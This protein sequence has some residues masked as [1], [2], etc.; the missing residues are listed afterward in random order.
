MDMITISLIVTGLIVMGLS[1]LLLIRAGVL[2][3]ENTA[4]GASG[5]IMLLTCILLM[6]LQAGIWVTL[7]LK[8]GGVI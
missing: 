7:G 5:L 2:A 3:A 6:N 8:L 1:F 4:R